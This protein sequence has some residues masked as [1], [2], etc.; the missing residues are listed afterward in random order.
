MDGNASLRAGQ[1]LRREALRFIIIITFAS[2][3]DN[4]LFLKLTASL[5][6]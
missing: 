1:E 5:E 6:A 2:D 3:K 4:S